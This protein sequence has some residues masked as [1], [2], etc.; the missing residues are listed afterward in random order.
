MKL[1]FNMGQV[2]MFTIIALTFDT[3]GSMW[4]NLPS[5]TFK[6]FDYQKMI[7]RTDVIHLYIGD[8][9]SWRLRLNLQ[10]IQ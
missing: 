4:N 3:H 5:K 9:R 1:Q 2:T 6:E 7:P 10:K 8:I